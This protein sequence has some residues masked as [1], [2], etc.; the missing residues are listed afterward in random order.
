MC[1][2]EKR[3]TSGNI[4]FVA[5]RA[6]VLNLTFVLSIGFCACGNGSA[7]KPALHKFV[8]LAVSLKKTHRDNDRQRI[9]K[10]IKNTDK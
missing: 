7:T 5:R 6:D 8:L 10:K 1:D 4:A 9:F 2:I 3:K